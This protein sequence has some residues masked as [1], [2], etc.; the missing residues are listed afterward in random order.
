MR[1]FRYLLF[2]LFWRDFDR[3]KSP[4]N[5][6]LRALVQVLV[7]QRNGCAFCADLNALHLLQ[8]A[9]NLDKLDAL[10]R[11]REEAVFTDS[12]KVALAYAEAISATPVVVGKGLQ[13]DVQ[14]HF[15]RE[16]IVELTGLVAFQNMSAKFNTAL[17]L[18][19]QGLCLR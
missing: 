10:A 18:P 2:M 9:G 13:E 12:E 1:P 17:D 16:E 11:Y 14:E 6:T 3:R 4:L 8:R 7:A 19:A 15:S 5:A